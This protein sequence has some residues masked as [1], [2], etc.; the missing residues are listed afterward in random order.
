MSTWAHVQACAG[1]VMWRAM[2]YPSGQA[3]ACPLEVTWCT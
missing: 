2:K 3:G 1:D